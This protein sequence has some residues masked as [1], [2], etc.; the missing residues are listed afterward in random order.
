MSSTDD[1]VRGTTN[2][3]AGRVKKA[4]GDLTGDQDLQAEGE[5]QEIAGTGQKALGDAKQ[6]VGNALH[7]AANAVKGSGD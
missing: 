7:N 3:V 2:Q 1:K 5:G 4:V 6:A